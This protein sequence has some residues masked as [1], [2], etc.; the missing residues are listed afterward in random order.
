MRQAANLVLTLNC[1]CCCRAS[2]STPRPDNFQPTRSAREALATFN[3]DELGAAPAGSIRL[4]RGERV[5]GYPFPS[6]AGKSLP[7]GLTQLDPGWPKVG[8]GMTR[9]RRRRMACKTVTANF[10][11]RIPAFHTPSGAPRDLPQRRLGKECLVGCAHLSGTPASRIPFD[12]ALCAATEI[13]GVV[14]L[15]GGAEAFDRDL[16]LRRRGRI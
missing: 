5:G 12:D 15:R 11:R 4:E 16:G 6:S 7:P 2:R 14:A 1:R 9:C 10:H 3:G 8:W 13:D